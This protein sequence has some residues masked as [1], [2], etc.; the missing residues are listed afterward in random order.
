MVNRD[1]IDQ[2]VLAFDRLKMFEHRARRRS[3]PSFV[4]IG[5][6]RAGSTSLYKLLRQHPQ[7]S[8][9]AVK[10]INYFGFR[11]RV[12]ARPWGMTFDEYQTYFIGAPER[13]VCGEISPSYFILP[14]A[15][16]EIHGWLP[17]CKILCGLRHPVDRLVSHYKYHRAQHGF[18]SFDAFIGN[19]RQDF[20]EIDHPR[21]AHHWF[22]PVR[23]LASSLYARPIAQC[24][25]LFGAARVHVYLFEDFVERPE[26]AAG[27]QEFLEVAATPIAV[28][29]INPSPAPDRTLSIGADNWRWLLE[30][31]EEDLARARALLG[32]GLER[33]A[34]LDD[35]PARLGFEAS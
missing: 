9:P 21:L 19:A 6:G 3:Q 17:Q 4:G 15:L 29:K 25:S 14:E 11:S 18:D 13:A 27:I 26:C 2:A 23:I 35:A 5:P 33:Y 34:R 28:E 31:F 10:E 16:R 7:V 22:K 24:L 12:D 8:L 1:E 32:S 20:A 30:V